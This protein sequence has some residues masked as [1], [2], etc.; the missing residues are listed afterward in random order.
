MIAL[1]S[2]STVTISRPADGVGLPQL[3]SI[4]I[5]N[6]CFK[7]VTELKLVG[8]S[9]LES[10]VV[11]DNSFVR[12]GYGSRASGVFQLKDC[13]KLKQLTTGSKSFYNY[14]TCEIQGVDALESIDMGESAFYSA[15]LELKS[16]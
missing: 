16:V 3:Q 5:G 12:S 13:P 15:S 14:A 2:R 1:V 6:D 7:K 10:V 8:L 11:G 9:R 4:V